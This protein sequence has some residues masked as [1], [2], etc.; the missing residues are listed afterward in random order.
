M[1]NKSKIK[2]KIKMTTCPDRFQRGKIEK[3]IKKVKYKI[4]TDYLPRQDST[5]ENR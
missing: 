5:R 4:K 1:K 2:I 3:L